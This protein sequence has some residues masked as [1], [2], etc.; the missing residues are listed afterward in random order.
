MSQSI[1]LSKL[2]S[3]PCKAY[4]LQE[5][6]VV[7]KTNADE[8]VISSESNAYKT[9]RIFQS[10]N[11]NILGTIELQNN[12]EYSCRVNL[13][14]NSDIAVDPSRNN[15]AILFKAPKKDFKGAYVVRPSQANFIKTHLNEWKENLKVVIPTSFLDSF[16]NQAKEYM[17]S[18]KVGSCE[19]DC[20]VGEKSYK[21]SFKVAKSADLT[22]TVNDINSKKLNRTEPLT[23]KQLALIEKYNALVK[24]E[25][26]GK[27]IGLSISLGERELRHS[28]WNPNSELETVEHTEL[29]KSIKSEAK[30]ETKSETQ[31]DLGDLSDIIG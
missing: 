24:A 9:V 6:I 25:K 11:P 4:K 27:V 18:N 26:E 16:E 19:F 1:K 3:A 10:N 29:Q 31:E 7:T 12:P 8:I 15:S 30:T 21:L 14:E 28:F 20:K 5:G 13:R 17:E 2:Q 23:D 22:S